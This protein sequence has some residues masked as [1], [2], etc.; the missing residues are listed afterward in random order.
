MSHDM[1]AMEMGHC[2]SPPPK[3]DQGKSTP[4]P[5]CVTMCMAVAV[6]SAAPEAPPPIRQST[7][8]FAHPEAYR[9]VLAEIATPP[10]RLS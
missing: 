7:A 2:S 10:P 3:H 6:A 4:K 5:C 8:T 9:G 1:A